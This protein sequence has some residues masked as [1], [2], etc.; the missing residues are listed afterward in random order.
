MELKQLWYFKHVYETG[1]FSRAANTLSITQQGLSLSIDKLEKELG[2]IFF[3]RSKAGVEPTE[4]A[5]A[6]KEDVDI[7][8]KNTTELK[9]NIQ[10]AGRQVN[11]IVKIGL[12]PAATPFFVPRLLT[13]FGERY[14][15]IK[16]DIKE[17]TDLTSETAIKQNKIDLA[18]VM[19]I[20]NSKNIEKVPL[21]EDEVMVVVR[22]DNPLAKR[23]VLRFADLDKESFILP[24]DD[25]NWYSSIFDLCNKAG[26]QPKIS[27]I[28]SD[29]GLTYGIVS[30]NN[31]IAFISKKF[32]SSFR[33]GETIAIPLSPKEGLSFR[34]SLIKKKGKTGHY[35]AEILFDYIRDISKTYIAL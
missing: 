5:K 19:D 27:Y 26:F 35:A 32:I 21:F 29:I 14:P 13:E 34:I 10:A 15:Y 30:A 23:E 6:F 2:V 9:A 25:F 17:M 12:T 3:L 31:S 28:T 20:V 1:S 18:C 16:L 33:E 22:K 24:P 7:I 8:L 11:G 4:I